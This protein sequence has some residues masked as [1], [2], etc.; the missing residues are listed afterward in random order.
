MAFLTDF[1]MG[2]QSLSEGS[3]TSDCEHGCD[4]TSEIGYSHT[5]TL[6]RIFCRRFRFQ[7]VE[8]ECWGRAELFGDIS[9]VID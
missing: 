2:L 4:I 7:A 6:S 1:F 8:E 5:N 9:Y 3:H